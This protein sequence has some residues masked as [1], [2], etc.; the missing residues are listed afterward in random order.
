[1][2]NALY[3]CFLVGAVT[4]QIVGTAIAADMTGDEINQGDHF[5]QDGLLGMWGRPVAGRPVFARALQQSADE[6]D[7]YGR[8]RFT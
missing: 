7:R 4:R 2:E 5:W 8:R 1:L 6:G 3:E